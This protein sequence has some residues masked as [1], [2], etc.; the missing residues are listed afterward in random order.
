MAVRSDIGMRATSWVNSTQCS[1]SQPTLLGASPLATH[2]DT[3]TLRRLRT[4]LHIHAKAW[5]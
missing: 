1:L 4:A 2:M 3:F 5:A